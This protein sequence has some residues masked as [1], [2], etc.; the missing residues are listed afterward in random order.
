MKAFW[1]EDISHI[2]ADNTVSPFEKVLVIQALRPDYLHTALSK[3]ASE[4]LGEL[5]FCLNLVESSV[6]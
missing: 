2:Y 4:Q 1:F 6:I 3:W 5:N